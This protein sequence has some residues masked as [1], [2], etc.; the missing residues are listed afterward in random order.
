MFN[1]SIGIRTAY[2]VAGVLLSTPAAAQQSPGATPNAS[3]KAPAKAAGGL[4]LK[5]PSQPL[6]VNGLVYAVAGWTMRDDATTPA[7]D[8]RALLSLHRGRLWFRGKPHARLNYVVQLGF[9]RTGA[10]EYSLLQGKAMSTARTPALLDARAQFQV[11][12]G[13]RLILTAGFF[14]APIGFES[15]AVGPALSSHEPGLTAVLARRGSVGA[16]HGRAAGLNLGG[17]WRTGSL[18][19][20]YQLGFSTPTASGLLPV[21]AGATTPAVAYG[22][23]MGSKASPLLATTVAVTW[24]ADPFRG[25]HLVHLAN[26]YKGKTSIALGASASQQGE[27]DLA[28]TSSVTTA[29][30]VAHIGAVNLDGE[31]VQAQRKANGSGDL[32]TTYARHV[33]LG[34]NQ[35]ILAGKALLE[36]SLLWTEMD[37]DSALSG[38]AAMK[39]FTGRGRLLDAALNLHLRAHKMRVSAHFIQAEKQDPGSLPIRAGQTVL[40]GLQLLH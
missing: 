32:A 3:P 5:A 24:G 30:A 39:L 10:D 26:T 19:I 15:N 33:R 12:S 36:P 40:V 6:V 31:W 29:F 27:T 18:G 14:R 4:W 35:R 38:A 37:G 16:G 13:G 11:L 25:G 2:L 8:D 34:Y 28:A 23:S 1:R 20:V 9:D 17:R 22:S 21:E 7:V